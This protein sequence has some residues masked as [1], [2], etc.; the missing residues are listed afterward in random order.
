M[1]ATLPIRPTDYHF[2]TLYMTT[3]WWVE[4]DPFEN[5]KRHY[6]GDNEILLIHNNIVVPK[7]EC[8]TLGTCCCSNEQQ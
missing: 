7:Q 4:H 3:K 6:N 8:D 2:V 1:C 5:T